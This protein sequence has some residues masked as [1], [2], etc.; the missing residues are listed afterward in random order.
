M[1]F[2]QVLASP[3]YCDRS[4]YSAQL[5][6]VRPKAAI[7][8]WSSQWLLMPSACAWSHPWNADLRHLAWSPTSSHLTCR[9]A[10]QT[11]IHPPSDPKNI[12]WAQRDAIRDCR[13]P[14]NWHQYQEQS[15]KQQHSRRSAPLDARNSCISIGL[16]PVTCC[17]VIW[18]SATWYNIKKWNPLC[19]TAEDYKL[20]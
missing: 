20:R 7:Q 16:Y 6:I 10:R 17:T 15:F 4:V 1:G 5:P 13:T 19:T 14:Q 12:I 9:S 11:I 8:T 3:L 2:C 18:S